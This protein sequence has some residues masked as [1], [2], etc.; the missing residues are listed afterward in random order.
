MFSGCVALYF[1]NIN[2]IDLAAVFALLGI[3]FDFF[4]GFFARLFKVQSELGLQLDSMADMITSGM[5][6][7]MI[8]FQLFKKSHLIEMFFP[9]SFPSTQPLDYLCFLGFGITLASGYRLA[10]FNIDSRQTSSFIGLPT[11]AN[12]LLVISVALLCYNQPSNIVAV[13]FSNTYVLTAFVIFSSY[14]LN[15]EIP[16]F[17]LK[18]KTWDFRQNWMRYTLIVTTIL[19]VILLNYTGILITILFYLLLSLTVNTISK[20]KL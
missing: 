9:V 17:A 5:V 6:P 12:T 2:Q 7:G 16:L 15:A 11:P 3:F 19:L 8:V 1:A 10:K 14:I 20:Q 13:A 18:F 4:D